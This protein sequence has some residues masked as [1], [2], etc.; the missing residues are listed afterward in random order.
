[1]NIRHESMKAGYAAVHTVRLLAYTGLVVSMCSLVCVL[2]AELVTSWS[3]RNLALEKASAA[4]RAAI[5]LIEKQAQDACNSIA[6]QKEARLQEITAR[7]DAEA[8]RLA[9]E[10]KSLRAELESLPQTYAEAVRTLN[11]KGRQMVAEINRTEVC[12][13]GEFPNLP[14]TRSDDES[15]RALD[16]ARRAVEA[17]KNALATWVAAHLAQIESALESEL[18]TVRAQHAAAEQ[19]LA[20][21]LAAHEP[22]TH[23]FTEQQTVVTTPTTLEANLYGEDGLEHVQKL[24]YILTSI[25]YGQALPRGLELPAE[26]PLKTN[27]ADMGKWLPVPPAPQEE[28]RLVENKGTRPWTEEEITRRRELQQQV[29]D[30]KRRIARLEPQLQQLTPLAKNVDALTRGHWEVD[31]A[32][33]H[34]SGVHSRFGEVEAALNTLPQRRE[35]AHQQATD[36]RKAAIAEAEQKLAAA[37]LTRKTATSAARLTAIQARNAARTTY[38][39][40]QSV[41]LL[42]PP[43]LLWLPATWALW[44]LLLVLA[45]YMACPLQT[46]LRL[47]SID[48]RQNKNK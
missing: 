29:A 20:A 18:A 47:Q 1:M 22:G 27:S 23:V 31:A 15:S 24:R 46:A 48:E 39:I 13:A 4:E 3:V 44:A 33:S 25:A 32:L 45:D 43:M 8:A 19:E 6:G 42:S 38:N 41:F 14:D 37:E 12:R 21:L 17:A 5:S 10:E 9:E 26:S 36:D 34:A 11:A 16:D 2:F 7:K 35:Q 30:L 28:Q 40:V